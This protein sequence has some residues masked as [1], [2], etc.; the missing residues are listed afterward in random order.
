MTKITLGPKPLIYPMPALIV[1]ANID[2]KANFMTAAWG[3]VA[4]GNPPMISVAIRPQ[5]HTLIGINQN[6][7]FSI[8]IPSTDLVRE[9][10]YCG[11]ASGS[12]V[13]KV[14]ACNFKVFYGKLD[15]VPL[16]EQCPVNMECK[17]AHRLELGSHI[18]VI[19]QIIE[20]HVSQDCCTDGQPD[21]DKINPF[22]YTGEYRGIG[23]LIAK[24]HSIG[25]EI[26]SK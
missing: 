21:V 9:T 26:E 5:R 1:G 15:N 10:D 24:A 16:I 13:D 6:M 19:G 18:L 20:T 22:C 23:E 11:I 17:V 4:N 12:K 14:E 25:K 8:N 3:G 2:G 7:C